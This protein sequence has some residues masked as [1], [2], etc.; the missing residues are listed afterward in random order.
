MHPDK[1]YYKML[2]FNH[3]FGANMIE[4][5]KSTATSGETLYNLK[6]KAANAIGRM[7]QHDPGT[8]PLSHTAEIKSRTSANQ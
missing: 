3:G 4:M 6:R 8:V 5:L 7:G 1:K 2:V